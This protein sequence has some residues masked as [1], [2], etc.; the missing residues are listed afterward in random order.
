MNRTM[1]NLA[2][3]LL[4]MAAISRGEETRAMTSESITEA[5][6]AACAVEPLAP[7]APFEASWI[8]PARS[9]EVDP[10]GGVF[11]VRRTFQVTNPAAWQ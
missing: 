11:E 8:G 2:A 9:A 3:G 6:W 7:P 4:L 5:K 1:L 10:L